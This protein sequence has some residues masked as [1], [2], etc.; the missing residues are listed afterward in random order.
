MISEGTGRVSLGGP[1][2]GCA[3]PGWQPLLPL[4]ALGGIV[5]QGQGCAPPCLA[6]PLPSS[7]LG[8]RSAPSPHLLQGKVHPRVFPVEVLSPS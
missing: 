2:Q 5:W 3:V 7:L 1:W 4:L 6:L 8:A